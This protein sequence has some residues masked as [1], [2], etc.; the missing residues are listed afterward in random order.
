MEQLELRLVQSRHDIEN[1]PDINGQL[2]S[3][4]GVKTDNCK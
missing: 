1:P 3:S 2:S 4:N